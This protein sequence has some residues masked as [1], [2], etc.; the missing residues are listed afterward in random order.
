MILGVPVFLGLTASQLLEDCVMNGRILTLGKR[1]ENS[2]QT[3]GKKTITS[4]TDNFVLFVAVSSGRLLYQSATAQ[5]GE[6][7]T[8]VE[9]T[10]RKLLELFSDSLIDDDAVL[11]RKTLLAWKEA[12]EN[13]LRN[14]DPCATDEKATA[15]LGHSPK[16]DHKVSTHFSERSDLRNV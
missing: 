8:E 2:T 10:M 1:R 13:L 4:C 5:P 16:E 6:S 15:Y 9:T 3:K 14:R 7:F 12:G 11:V